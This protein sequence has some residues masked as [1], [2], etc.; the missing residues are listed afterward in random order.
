MRVISSIDEIKSTKKLAITIG[1]FDGVHLGHQVFLRQI[2]SECEKKD[3]IFVVVTFIPHP[4]QILAP[5]DNY[6]INRYQDRRELLKEQE[7]DFLLEIDFQYQL[8]NFLPQD[9]AQPLSNGLWNLKLFW[10]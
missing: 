1:N 10:P 6:L 7:V 3:R 5:S 2:K 8:S 9:I 4:L